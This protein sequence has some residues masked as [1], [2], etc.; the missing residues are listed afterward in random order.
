MG[1]LILQLSP[2][3]DEA[4]LVWGNAFAAF[5]GCTT[6]LSHNGPQGS[7]VCSPKGVKDL[8]AFKLAMV[9]SGPAARVSVNPVSVFTNTTKPGVGGRTTA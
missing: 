2:L 3:K 8:P 1:G 4:L 6:C 7:A 9:Q 5:Y